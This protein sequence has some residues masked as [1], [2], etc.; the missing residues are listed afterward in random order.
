MDPANPSRR[1]STILLDPYQ[2]AEKT[3][4]HFLDPSSRSRGRST[5]DPASERF[6]GMGSRSMMLPLRA[7]TCQNSPDKCMMVV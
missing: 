4:D 1:E 7:R 2:A 3:T 5:V 6:F